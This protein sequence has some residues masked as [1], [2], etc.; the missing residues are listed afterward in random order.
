MASKVWLWAGAAVLL[1]PLALL[2][3]FKIDPSLEPWY[4]NDPLHFWGISGVALGA[5]LACAVLITSAPTL[6]ETRLLFLALSFLTIA[7]VFSVHG[8]MTSGYLAHSF[9]SSVDASP[10]ISTLLGGVF[11]ALS[12]TTLPPPV[13][14]FVR[15]A[16][17][18]IFSWTAVAL[19]IFIG[20][21]LTAR[22]WLDTVPTDDMGFT[23]VVAAVSTALY[24]FAIR[25]YIEA[26]QFARLPSQGAMVACL[27]LLAQVPALTLWGEP[28]YALWWIYHALYGV[29]F[30]VLL[31]GW[32]IEARRARSL[33]VIAE[34]LSMRD[35]LA[36]LNRGQDRHVVELVDAIEAKDV[37]TLGHVDRVARYSMA[38]GRQLSLSPTQ[39]RD[40]ALAAQMH[41]VGKLGVPDAILRKPASLTNDEYAEIKKHSSRGFEIATRVEALRRI[42][43]VIRAHHERLNGQGYPDG[44]RGDEIPLLARIIAVAD[45]YDAITSTRPYRESLGHDGAVVE[46]E[47]VSGTELDARCVSAFLA[48]FSGHSAAAAA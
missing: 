19:V 42:A 18:M 7:G 35:A 29:A 2:A 45:T 13:E 39:L 27:A 6:R 8:L 34:G 14:R 33:S 17:M 40:L 1:S 47:R 11:V 28:G 31:F 9:H 4:A 44:L 24:A 41:D 15:R 5:A 23:Y 32:A 12:V 3:V 43:P 38:I 26:Y 36:Q 48:S 22:D 46:L 21:S 37:A 30:A 10:W 25:R 16:G 20:L